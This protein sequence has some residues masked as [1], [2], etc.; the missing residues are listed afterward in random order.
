MAQANVSRNASSSFITKAEIKSNKDKSKV[1]SLLGGLDA[2]GPRLARLMYFESILQDTVKAEIMFDDTGGAIDGKSTIEGLPLVGTEEVNIA[3]EDNNQNKMKVTLYI[4]KVTPAYEDTKKSR[5]VINMVSEEFL[6]NEDIKSRLNTRF[7]GKISE[8]IKK[9]LK[10]NL[11]TKKKTDIE[12]TTNNY[13]FI[14]NNRKPYYA[15]NWLSKAAVPSKDGKKGDSAGFFFFET[16]EGFKFKSIDSLFAQEKKRS[17]IFNE[18]SD[19]DGQVPAGYDGKVLEQ[20]ADNAVDVQ[21]KLQMGAYGTRLVLF[22]PF[23]CEYKVILQTADESKKGTKLAGK[24]L[25]VLNEKFK[26]TCTRT[27]YMLLDVGTLPTGGVKEQIGKSK[28]QNFETQSVLNQAIRRYNQMF[29]GMQ[30]ITI[31]GDFSLHAGDKVFLDTPGLRPL[32]SDEL[33]KEYSGEYIIADLCHYITP[34]E[35]YTKMNLVRDSFG[36]KG[37]HTKR[38]PL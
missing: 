22:N 23:T 33:N 6:R 14:G 25:P 17:L 19:K 1:V 11:K 5:I 27:T 24:D 8:H 29:A 12:E 13:N 2:P 32:K 16:S 26:N 38:I 18:S 36:R 28:D 37:N 20:Q 34:N 35:T 31:A 9:I 7:D 10:N 3:F 21:D 30:T 4:N 15:L